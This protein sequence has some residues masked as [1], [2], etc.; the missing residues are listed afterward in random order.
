MTTLDYINFITPTGQWFGGSDVAPSHYGEYKPIA[1]DIA[2]VERPSG[3]ITFDN[4][5]ANLKIV[6]GSGLN[7]PFDRVYVDIDGYNDY[8]MLDSNG[9]GNYSASGNDTFIASYTSGGFWLM[10]DGSGN[11]PGVI[12]VASGS[13]PTNTADILNLNWQNLSSSDFL[14]SSNSLDLNSNTAIVCTTEL[15]FF[16]A[17][18]GLLEYIDFDKNEHSWQEKIYYLTI[19]GF[20]YVVDELGL[21]IRGKDSNNVEKTFQ[22][23][24][25]ELVPDGNAIAIA[26]S[27]NEL[28]GRVFTYDDIISGNASIYL[29]EPFN[30]STAIPSTYAE[31]IGATIYP[32]EPTISYSVI[33][34]HT[35]QIT[36]DIN[37]VISPLRKLYLNFSGIS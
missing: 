16:S 22:L 37:N 24:Y 31:Y 25:G 4:L 11:S 27:G 32:D 34:D 20:Q 30:L 28:T 18:G 21:I 33:D 2:G 3:I 15:P 14:F 10:G 19:Y 5:P 7:L 23:Y 36:S 26:W 35:I 29:P 1:T 17:T 12:F 13:A 8:V 9:D 6:S